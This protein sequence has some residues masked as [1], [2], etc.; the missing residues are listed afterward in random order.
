[1]RE[2]RARADRPDWK[3]ATDVTVGLDVNHNY[4]RTVRTGKPKRES[5]E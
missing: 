5:Q 1:M 2:P 4:T 3:E